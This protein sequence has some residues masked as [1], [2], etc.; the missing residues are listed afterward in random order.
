MLAKQRRRPVFEHIPRAAGSAAEVT[1]G[2]AKSKP[3]PAL[4][5]L[6]CTAHGSTERRFG[7]R[8][9]ES[10]R[11]HFRLAL[12]RFSM[13]EFCLPRERA[14]PPALPLEASRGSAAAGGDVADVTVASPIPSRVT[15]RV[16]KGQARAAVRRG[17][18][19][20]DGAAS[21]CGRGRS[22]LARTDV[23]APR[24]AEPT[25]LRWSTSTVAR[26]RAVSQASDTTR[27]DGG[28]EVEPKSACR[29][30]GSSLSIPH[31][32]DC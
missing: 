13:P 16:R 18:S 2:A 1:A 21:R 29:L 14:I 5:S 27:T 15:R 24:T 32:D 19:L 25:A 17:C 30:S 8:A 9:A 31:V 6:G 20:T 10:H 26:P 7:S 12:L 23:S 22:Q 3:L 4:P 28:A 11:R